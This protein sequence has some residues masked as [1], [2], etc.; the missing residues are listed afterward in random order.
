ML[1]FFLLKSNFTYKYIYRKFK[2]R[3]LG[4]AL[5]KEDQDS[6]SRSS[7]SKLDLNSSQK[8]DSSVNFDLEQA[9]NSYPLN[10]T[11]NQTASAK[12]DEQDSS[13]VVINNNNNNGSKYSRRRENTDLNQG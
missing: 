11:S 1:A 9:V 3:I 4:N 6:T 5:L 12:T 7:I 10:G 2:F 8:L 13:P